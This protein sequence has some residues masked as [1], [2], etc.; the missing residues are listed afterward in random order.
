M[1]IPMRYNDPS[2]EVIG[3]YPPGQDVPWS[4][5]GG[6]VQPSFGIIDP[7]G[8]W[9]G[10]GDLLGKPQIGRWLG[11]N[12]DSTFNDIG[13][14]FKSIFNPGR[15]SQLVWEPIPVQNVNI[16]HTGNS[17]L[18]DNVFTVGG[19]PWGN[20]SQ[21]KPTI[22]DRWSEGNILEQTIYETLNS[23]SIAAQGLNPFDNQITSLTGEDLTDQ[24]QTF[25]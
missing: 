18:L 5:S 19:A 10:I 24:D 14:F 2:G 1:I 8:T 4:I 20:I 13:N 3:N 15:D 21:Y 6:E 11:R 9:N 22:F 17:E 7:E 23:F 16:V 12:L 25:L